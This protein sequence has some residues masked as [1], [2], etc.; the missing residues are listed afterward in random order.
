[1]RPPSFAGIFGAAPASARVEEERKNMNRRN[2]ALIVLAA[3]LPALASDRPGGP[4]SAPAG[5]TPAAGSASSR[6]GGI[7]VAPIVT[8]PNRFGTPG[9]KIKLEADVQQGGSALSGFALGFWVDGEGAGHATTDASGKATLDYKIPGTFVQK[10]YEV[11]ATAPHVEGKGDLS[12]FK[13]ATKMTVGNFSWGTYKGEPGSPSGTYTFTLTRTSDGNAIGD[14]PVP[15]SV[16][17]NGAPYNPGNIK[18]DAV[19]MP[20]PPLPAGQKTW[21]VKVAFAGNASY[22][23]SSDE[24]TFTKP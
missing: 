22:L 21:K 9:E 20:L 8:L 7:Q 1:L 17:V 16:F 24:K 2:F 12:I 3:S 14:P 5:P 18:S 6:A 23:A 13:S 4:A 11:K 10:H 19:L 15:V